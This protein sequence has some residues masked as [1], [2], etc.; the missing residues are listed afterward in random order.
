M[1]RK[2]KVPLPLV[3]ENLK[4][5]IANTQVK[6]I[7]SQT[8]L[9]ACNIALK[10]QLSYYDSLI[11]TAALEFNCTTLYSEDMQNGQIIEYKL[12]IVNPFVSGY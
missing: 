2:M 8:V 12:K 11:V 6:T 5:I 3:T 1:Y 4:E 7:S 9:Q 10:N